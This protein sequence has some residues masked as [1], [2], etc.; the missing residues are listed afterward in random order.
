MARLAVGRIVGAVSHNVDCTL[1][2]RDTPDGPRA[3]RTRNIFPE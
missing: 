2:Q 1:A 3:G